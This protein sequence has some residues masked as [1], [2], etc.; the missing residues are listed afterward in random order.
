MLVI[1][2]S[3]NTSPSKETHYLFLV[4]EA[5][6]PFFW[7]NLCP[8]KLRFDEKT[9]E[10]IYG[11]VIMQCPQQTGESFTP[12][13]LHWSDPSRSGC[14]T[15]I[16]KARYVLDVTVNAQCV[17]MPS[18]NFA[19]KP[20]GRKPRHDLHLGLPLESELNTHTVDFFL[21]FKQH[22]LNRFTVITSVQSQNLT[23]MK[24]SLIG[25][26]CFPSYS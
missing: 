7:S 24:K 25:T 8:L 11:E 20:R 13:K 22:S 15:Y 16:C 1:T 18:W 6:G 12:F 10:G 21:K 2:I 26:I 19:L 4:I 9:A 14:R 5:Q 3:P 23:S 17:Q